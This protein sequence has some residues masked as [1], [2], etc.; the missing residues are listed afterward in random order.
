MGRA[1]PSN[2]LCLSKTGD[3]T[4]PLRL[5]LITIFNKSRLLT[6]NLL[7]FCL[8]LKTRR[9]QLLYPNLASVN[10]SHRLQT[11][12]VTSLDLHILLL[13]HVK[14]QL[15]HPLLGSLPRL[16]SDFQEYASALCTSQQPWT[17]QTRLWSFRPVTCFCVY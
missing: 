7:C 10:H 2:S 4:V 11:S 8:I 3:S 14:S 16:G 17:S 1:A 5:A 6:D 15:M 12:V 13:S 9:F